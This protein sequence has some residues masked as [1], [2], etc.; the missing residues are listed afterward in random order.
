ME[1]YR[2]KLNMICSEKKA[3]VHIFLSISIEN[4]GFTFASIHQKQ[5][6]VP[7]LNFLFLEFLHTSGRHIK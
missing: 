6:P 4:R 7:Y 1:S 3:K 5:D 2:K